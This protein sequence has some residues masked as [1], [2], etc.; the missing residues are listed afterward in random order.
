MNELHYVLLTYLQAYSQT[1]VELVQQDL[2][3]LFFVFYNYVDK[4][5]L[6]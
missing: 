6:T 4:S 3:M 2:E 1:L 5:H